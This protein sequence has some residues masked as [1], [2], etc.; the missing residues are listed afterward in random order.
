M[1][2]SSMKTI[3]E[4]RPVPPEDLKANTEP[5]FRKIVIETDGTRIKVTTNETAGGLELKAVLTE[6]LASFR[7]AQ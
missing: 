4:I 6:I 7:N 1:E 5:K 3:E 2:N